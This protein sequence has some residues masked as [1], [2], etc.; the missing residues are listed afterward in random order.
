MRSR[1]ARLNRELLDSI[2][3]GDVSRVRTLLGQGADVNA[4]HEEHA[5]TP[6]ILAVKFSGADMMKFLLEAGVEVDARDDWG[7]TALFYAPVS[8]EKFGVLLRAGADISARDKEG[9]TILMQ[10]VSRCASVAEVDQLLRL[11][12]DASVQNEYGENA[13]DLAESLGLVRVAERIRL[14]YNER[15]TN[16]K[17]S[18][19]EDAP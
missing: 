12:V 4:K 9:N 5:E 16:L 11:G 7:R 1:R 3:S 15:K 19:F 18:S 8:S 6:L 13:L 14:S 17:Q 10:E 2:I